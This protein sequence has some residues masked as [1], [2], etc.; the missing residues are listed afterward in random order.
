MINT[1]VINDVRHSRSFERLLTLHTPELNICHSDLYGEAVF[2]TINQL[3]PSLVIMDLNVPNTD[4]FRLFDLLEYRN[5]FLVYCA[6]TYGEGRRVPCC[7]VDY[8]LKPV[9][10]QEL[11]QLVAQLKNRMSF[12]D[13]RPAE[14]F[15]PNMYNAAGPS[16]TAGNIIF[17]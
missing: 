4:Q 14:P 11:L 17:S 15:T 5:F 13:Y 12:R 2:E 9:D 3:K 10:R 7:G 8:L 6:V 1:I 16:D